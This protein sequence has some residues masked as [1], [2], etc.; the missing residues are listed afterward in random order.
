[1]MRAG[2][3]LRLAIVLLIAAGNACLSAIVFSVLEEG[4]WAVYWQADLDA[5]PQ[6]VL[7]DGKTDQSSARFGNDGKTVALENSRNEIIIL[8]HAADA[9]SWKA[10]QTISNGVRPAWNGAMKTWVFVRYTLTATGE[11]SDVQQVS[12]DGKSFV[13]VRHTG[14]QDFPHISPNGSR[15]AYT[16]TQVVGVWQGAVNPFQQLWIVDFAQGK[17]RPLLLEARE[18]VEP[19]WSPSGEELAFASNKTG[20]F[21]IWAVRADGTGLRQVTS[22]PGAKTRP[23]WSPDGRRLIFTQFQEGRYGFAIVDADG[24]NQRSYKPFGEQ[25]IVEVRDADWK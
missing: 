2:H 13:L 24:K 23:A 9:S 12:T 3:A 17:T 22:G 19:A 16:S 1:M 10:L 7:N 8:Q 18:N 15:L 21:E 14:N 20:T 4:R 11:D 5:K 25:R 6:R